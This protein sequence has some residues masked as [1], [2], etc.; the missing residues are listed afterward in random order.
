MNFVSDAPAPGQVDPRDLTSNQLA[1]LR[2]IKAHK[3]NRVA[4]GWRV[5]GLPLVTFAMVHF[6]SAKRLIIR[7]DFR[8]TPRLELTGVGINTLT[9]AD[10]KKR[11]AA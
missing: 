2:L 4:K 7:R 10:A 3:L 6:L 1:A 11:N 9:V 8:G 5:Q